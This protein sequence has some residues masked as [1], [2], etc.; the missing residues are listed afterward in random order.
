MKKGCHFII[1]L[2]FLFT[3]SLFT[4]ARA[5]NAPG[6][7]VSDTESF[8][9]ALGGVR[10]AVSETDPSSQQTYVRI[11]G[12]IT[13]K[14]PLVFTGGNFRLD[15]DGPVRVISRDSALA[16]MIIVEEDAFLQLGSPNGSSINLILDGGK[17]ESI[18]GGDCIL[19]CRGLASIYPNVSVQ[20]F[21]GN[22]AGILI[23][24]SQAGVSMFGG[25]INNNNSTTGSGGGIYIEHGTF[26]MMGGSVSYNS[27]FFRGGGIFNNGKAYLF[28]GTISNN[29]SAQGGAVYL[30]DSSFFSIAGGRIENNYGN[31]HAGI[32]LGNAFLGLEGN[33]AL[34]TNAIFVSTGNRVTINDTLTNTIPI[35]IFPENPDYCSSFVKG[36]SRYPV[37]YVSDLERFDFRVTEEYFP[38]LSPDAESISLFSNP[39]VY[40]E[41]G[42]YAIYSFLFDSTF[43]ESTSLAK[44][45]PYRD[46]CDSLVMYRFNVKNDY[47]EEI[48]INACTEDL[49][50][51]YADSLL[52]QTGIYEFRYDTEYYCDSIEIVYFS[53]NPSYRDS[54]FHEICSN[55]F[56]YF[57]YDTVFYEEGDYTIPLYS[58]KQC[59]SILFLQLRTLPVATGYDTMA[60]C[61]GEFPVE[62]GDSLLFGPGNYTISFPS[63][64]GCDS[65][66][67]L[68][69]IERPSYAVT[70]TVYLCEYQFPYLYRDS[71]LTAAGTYDFSYFTTANCD[72]SFR[73][74]VYM[75][76]QI[77]NRIEGETDLCSGEST[78][79]HVSGLPGD[80]YLWSNGEMTSAISVEEAGIYSV[81]VS[82]NNGCMASDTVVIT[83]TD[84]PV[85][86]LTNDT[87][88]C[89]NIAVSLLAGG[90]SYYHWNTGEEGPQ[91]TVAEA[92]TYYLTA[93]NSPRCSTTDSV[94]VSHKAVPQLSLNSERTVCAGDSITLSV[95]DTSGVN[96]RYIWSTGETA[97]SIRVAPLFT[98]VYNVTATN[99]VNCNAIGETTVRTI[100]DLTVTGDTVI[101]GSESIILTAS[102]GGSYLWST[103]ETTPQI[104]VHV[105]GT[106]TVTARTQSCTVSLSR[107]ISWH[108]S[109]AAS[110]SPARPVVF[111]RGDSTVLIA[112]GGN[113]YLWN[114][115]N[116]ERNITVKESGKYTVIVTNEYGCSD[117]A[118]IDVTVNPIPEIRI[119]GSTEICKG[120]TTYLTAEGADSYLWNNGNNS[121]TLIAAPSQTTYYQVTATNNSGCRATRF[122]TLTVHPVPEAVVFGNNS[123]CAGESEILT[124][125]GGKTY[126]WSTGD[127]TKTIEVNSTGLYTVTVTGDGNCYST[128]TH[129]LNV[130]PSPDAE[131]F[132]DTSICNGTSTLLSATGGSSYF[133]NTGATTPS[134]SIHREGT[135]TVTVSNNQNCFKIVSVNVTVN[136]SP[137]IRIE[138]ERL[139]CQNES[140]VLKVIGNGYDYLW[141]EGKTDDSITVNH[142][143]TYTVTATNEWG[144]SVAKSVNIGTLPV[145]SPQISGNLTICEGRQ[146]ILT[147][148]GGTSYVWSTGETTPYIAVNSTGTYTVTATNAS[149][150]RTDVSATVIV[151]P[152][153]TVTITGN[154]TLCHGESTT[155]FAG[156]GVSYAWTTGQNAPFITVSPGRTT[157]Y[158]VFVTSDNQCTSYQDVTVTVHPVPEATIE[159]E[160]YFCGNESKV[161]TASGGDHYTWSNGMTG[162]RITVNQPGNYSVTVSSSGCSA[163]ASHTISR[164]PLPEVSISGPS[165]MC[166]GDSATLTA[167]G[168]SSY[169]WSNSGTSPSVTVGATG[170]YSVTATNEY[171]C[172]ASA[173]L[174]LLVHSV[175]NVAITGDTLLCAGEI[176]TLRAEGEPGLS[177]LWNTDD[178]S[179]SITVSERGIYTVTASNAHCFSR[180]RVYVDIHTPPAITVEGARSVCPGHST[181]LTAAGGL[182]YRWS[183]GI[184]TAVNTVSPLHTTSYTV[185]VTDEYGCT[186]TETIPVSIN[187]VPNVTLTGDTTFCE[188]NFTVLRASGASQFLWSTGQTQASITVY[189]PGTYTVTATNNLGCSGSKSVRIYAHPSPVIHISG[190]PVICEG[191]SATL[192]VSPQNSYTWSTGET[193]NSL[194]VN[195]IRTTVYGVTATNIHSCSASENITVTV[196]PLP[197]PVIEGDTS[198][199]EGDYTVLRASGGNSYLWDTGDTSDTIRINS[200]GEYRITVTNG[201][202][203][204]ATASALVTLHTLPAIRL[205]GNTSFCE[206]EHTVLYAS[207][208]TGYLWNNGSRNDSLVVTSPGIYSVTVTNEYDCP[209]NASIHV[210]S[211]ESPIP[212]I[213]GSSDLCLGD[214]LILEAG[215]GIHYLWDDGSATSTI[216]VK[217][218]ITTLYGVTATNSA[219]CSAGTSFTVHVHPHYEKVIFDEVCQGNP[220]RKHGF[221][222]PVQNSAGEFSHSL[223]L[224]SLYGCDSTVNLTLTVK[225]LPQLTEAISGLSYISSLGNYTY[226]MNNA[227]HTDIYQWTLSNPNWALSSGTTKNVTL[228]IRT[229]GTGTLSVIGINECGLSN[230]QSL[231]IHS[232]VSVSE[233]S[234]PEEIKLYPVPATHYLTV[235]NNHN[236]YPDMEIAIYD[237]HGKLVDT[238]YT[239]GTETRIPL[240][241]YADGVYVIRIGCKGHQIGSAKI[242]KQ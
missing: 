25:R 219:G 89:S 164:Y 119:T 117:T 227:L 234:L 173:S 169:V 138:G 70:D 148:S 225:P 50:Y 157:T 83:V 41:E 45:I 39:V 231:V 176:T 30:A 129:T 163:A 102:G 65:M 108:E 132:G 28:N 171:G 120:E 189:E 146:T 98:T 140:T 21:N 44:Y 200:P 194:T 181:T 16:Q 53:V 93:G 67:S 24:G 15:S 232:A 31:S 99:D 130:R 34:H 180:A 155:L 112:E 76:P 103:G 86:Q 57:L 4:P 40:E 52:Y 95:E 29:R 3:I 55:E 214:S 222:L 126:R 228:D 56:P 7:I 220:Y 208:G 142:A 38:Y 191:E 91:I 195:P 59:D 87:V 66:V 215:G 106:Y 77:S 109:P 11:T 202:G 116:R 61:S 35:T 58:E 187:P 152:S 212:F 36:S 47:S 69:V 145:P 213:N 124:A 175:P 22:Y 150:C 206:G 133:W 48:H 32:Y 78:F 193:G 141:S 179:S 143:G 182:S 8:I 162:N 224:H 114:T 13:L 201:N 190:N 18:Q 197:V 147:V 159:G 178:I 221:N 46:D 60:V 84:I 184:T 192:T 131:I 144:C 63:G 139:F 79:L 118:S 73:L 111:C 125:E 241:E 239:T 198:L 154:T 72:S 199:C 229:P 167:T 127:T 134:I 26:Y 205:S 166:H 121:P 156:G 104:T 165:N 196:H 188:G 81:T 242:V 62:Y 217:P 185:T 27:S 238:Y 88:V 20:N 37:L 49:P 10:N 207:G 85:L 240:Q 17:N 151:N 12:N 122:I 177:F 105:P 51:R 97:A 1:F 74:V 211:L 96:T 210:S 2:F 107:H 115:G 9:A 203:C 82:H 158:T 42:C 209:A 23:E 226:V 149:G 92:G 160:N 237:L 161:L 236:L 33:V 80:T 110:I 90:A 68:H 113:N 123:L 135:Y 174:N 168:G 235:E 5:A 183:N 230:S 101:C 204:M 218:E 172:S 75:L 64:P 94:K 216:T 153:P 54:V 223:Y 100:P 136:P 170:I 14:S 71:L 128:A 19:K 43:H 137:E 186:A 233:F 6:G